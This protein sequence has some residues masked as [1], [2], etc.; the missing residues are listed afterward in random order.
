MQGVIT[1]EL[2]FWVTKTDGTQEQAAA[3]MLKDTAFGFIAP[4]SD[5]TLTIQTT[6]LN[7]DSV[8][9]LQCAFGRLSGVS[10][11]LEINNGYRIF[12][13]TLN[14]VL[15]HKE[16]NFPSNVFGLFELRSLT[17]SYY[18]NY[19]YAGLTPIFIGP[20]AFEALPTE[21]AFII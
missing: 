2:Q 19:I 6:K 7:V 15:S 11:K 10:I 17:L 14:K 9:V 8:D 12:E 1:L 3:L 13:P 21:D 18:D 20:S 16:I 4:V 5:L